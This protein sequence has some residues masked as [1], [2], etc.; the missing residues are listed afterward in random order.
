MVT[1]LRQRGGGD[2][3]T[4]AGHLGSSLELASHDS[5]GRGC[6]PLTHPDAPAAAD[7]EPSDGKPSGQV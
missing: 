1:M 6:S 7:P 5:P 4:L 2:L 3:E